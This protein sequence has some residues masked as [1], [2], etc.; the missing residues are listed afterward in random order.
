[1]IKYLPNFLKMWQLL[2][3]QFLLIYS[4]AASLVETRRRQL[5]EAADKR[6]Q[7]QE[8]RGI[9]DPEKVKRMKQRSEEM[10]RRQEEAARHGGSGSELKDIKNNIESP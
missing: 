2:L 10:E 1:M 7:E 5:A 6:Q 9:K 3:F 4:T 8:N